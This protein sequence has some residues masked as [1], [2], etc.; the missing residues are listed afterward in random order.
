MGRLQKGSTHVGQIRAP[1]AKVQIDHLSNDKGHLDLASCVAASSP[2]LTTLLSVEEGGQGNVVWQNIQS[3]EFHGDQ[4]GRTGTAS[5]LQGLFRLEDGAVLR[6]MLQDL[7]PHVTAASVAAVSIAAAAADQFCPHPH[8][9]LQQQQQQQQQVP[10]HSCWQRVMRVA[11]ARYRPAPAAMQPTMQPNNM[12]NTMQS[13]ASQEKPL[14]ATLLPQQDNEVRML[15]GY[16]IAY[17]LAAW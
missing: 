9:H 8:P 15:M 1:D 6:D 11:A 17:L 13:R 4:V 10:G 5:F 12:P 14:S 2:Y 3:L 7:A 16:L